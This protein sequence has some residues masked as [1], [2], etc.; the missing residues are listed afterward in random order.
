MYSYNRLRDSQEAEI[1]FI[2]ALEKAK[3]VKIE[4]LKRQLAEKDEQIERLTVIL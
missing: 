4:L 3:L 1:N 2:E